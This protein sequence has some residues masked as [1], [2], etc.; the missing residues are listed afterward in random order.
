MIPDKKKSVA[1]KTILKLNN[2]HI[3]TSSLRAF[4]STEIEYGY[5]V[6]FEEEDS[7]AFPFIL[8]IKR[9][10]DKR[11]LFKFYRNFVQNEIAQFIKQ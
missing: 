3:K 8:G 10:Y 2:F 7:E 4:V 6:Q 9:I 1:E 11:K 5:F